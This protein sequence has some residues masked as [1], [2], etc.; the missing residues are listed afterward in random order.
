MVLQ[1]VR[2]IRW[3]WGRWVHGHLSLGNP[4]LKKQSKQVFWLQDF[5]ETWLDDCVLLISKKR[6]GRNLSPNVLIPKPFLPGV[7]WAF[8]CYPE[9][10]CGI[11][12]HDL[13]N[14]EAVWVQES[15]G[16]N[17]PGRLSQ[18][19]ESMELRR[20]GSYFFMKIQGKEGKEVGLS[21]AELLHR[22]RKRKETS[23]L[24]KDLAQGWTGA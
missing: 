5:P 22:N 16:A 12:W 11:P 19:R 1:V 20:R 17:C 4:A 24:E 10:I 2:V 7:S 23:K 8:L 6:G 15:Y 18:S 13:R 14:S 3:G 21:W 9:C